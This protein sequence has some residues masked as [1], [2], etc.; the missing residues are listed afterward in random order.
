[1][2]GSLSGGGEPPP[3]QDEAR[4]S[5]HFKTQVRAGRQTGAPRAVRV[6]ANW[7]NSPLTPTVPSAARRRPTHCSGAPPLPGTGSPAPVLFRGSR[8]ARCAPALGCAP[9]CCRKNAVQQKRSWVANLVILFM[10][11]FFCLLLFILQKV[12]GVMQDSCPGGTTRQDPQLR[13][14]YCSRL[15]KRA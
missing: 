15:M 11:I 8:K 6:P 12:G 4:L 14:A 1:M 5:A 13:V 7:T 9:Q 2:N 3:R 10:P